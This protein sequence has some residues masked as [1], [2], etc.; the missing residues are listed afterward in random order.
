MKHCLELAA[1]RAGWGR[2]LAAGRGRGLACCF[3]HL[4]YAAVV[5]EA[6]VVG[7]RVVVHRAVCAADCGTVIHPSG[8]RAQVEG[9]ITQGLSAALHER[10]T[11]DRGS[12]EQTNF[13]SYPLLR[14]N[15]APTAI[16]V[17]FVDR[18]D[19]RVTGLGEPALPPV[20]PALAS[21]LYRITGRRL[22]E[23]PLAG[24][25]GGSQSV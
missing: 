7:G 19:V 14:F 17:Y 25:L 6:S 13:N 10:I 18:P 12:V 5:I 24:T 2:P 23:L 3:D 1:N 4:S 8:A 9:S 20:A 11:I 21:A 22:R 16:E 15:E